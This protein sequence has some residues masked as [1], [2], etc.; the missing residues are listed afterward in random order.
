MTLQKFTERIA[1]SFLERIIQSFIILTGIK[2]VFVGT[3]AT[4]FKITT[5]SQYY[6]ERIHIRRKYSKI[7]IGA[8]VLKQIICNIKIRYS[9]KLDNV[10]FQPVISKIADILPVSV[11]K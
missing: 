4:G 1:N 8:D 2:D 10:D 11:L 3:D 9:S 7:S 5:C 6:I